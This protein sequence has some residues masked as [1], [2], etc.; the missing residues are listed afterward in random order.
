LINYFALKK[1]NALV[2]AGA[3]GIENFNFI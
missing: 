3:Q 2:L 1:W